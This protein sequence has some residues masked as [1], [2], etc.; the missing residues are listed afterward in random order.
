[1]KYSEWLMKHK[2]QMEARQQTPN[3]PACSPC[4]SRDKIEDIT[5]LQVQVIRTDE[6]IQY[7]TTALDYLLILR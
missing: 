2:P 3:C 5:Q 4:L 7:Q 1:M 6:N